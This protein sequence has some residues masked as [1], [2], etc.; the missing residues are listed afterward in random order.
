MQYLLLNID[1]EAGD[2]HLPDSTFRIDYK[3]HIKKMRAA[4]IHVP[5]FIDAPDWGKRID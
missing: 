4:S 5:L 3:K 1:N 2:W